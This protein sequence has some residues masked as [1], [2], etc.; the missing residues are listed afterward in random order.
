MS[1]KPETLLLSLTDVRGIL[2]PQNAMNMIQAGWLKPR[3]YRPTKK[4]EK[5][6]YARSDVDE[7][8]ARVYAGEYPNPK[9]S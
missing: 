7:C 6:I 5:P 4:G 8:I 9:A 2:G 3:S 1:A